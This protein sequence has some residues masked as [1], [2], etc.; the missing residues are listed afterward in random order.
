MTPEQRLDRLE[1][2][3]RLFIAAEQRRRKNLREQQEKIA[4]LFFQ[5]DAY[6]G[7]PRENRKSS[8]ESEYFGTELHIE[9]KM[10]HITLLHDVVF[11]L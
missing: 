6:G 2:V 11:S 9:S 3:A 4:Q 10:R 8:D 7:G 1:A 5:G